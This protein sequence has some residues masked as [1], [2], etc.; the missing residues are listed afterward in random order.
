MLNAMLLTIGARVLAHAAA[1]FTTFYAPDATETVAKSIDMAGTIAG[2]YGGADTLQHG[3][4]RADDFSTGE[5]L[6]LQS[7]PVGTLKKVPVVK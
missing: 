6:A 7:L 4:V 2:W 3:F 5:H 1:K